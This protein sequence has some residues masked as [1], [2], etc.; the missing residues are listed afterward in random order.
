MPQFPLDFDTDLSCPL[1]GKR[2]VCP[3]VLW[4]LIVPPLSRSPKKSG[5]PLF[6]EIPIVKPKAPPSRLLST[7]SLTFFVPPLASPPLHPDFLLLHTF[8]TPRGLNPAWFFKQPE[9]RSICLR[10]ST[11]GATRRSLLVWDQNF[12][13]CGVLGV[14]VVVVWGL[15]LLRC[16]G[17]FGGLEC[18][19]VFFFFLRGRVVGVFCWVLVLQPD[20][21]LYPTFS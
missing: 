10:P 2:F 5:S 1:T 15:V 16:F 21:R 7:I 6:F 9:Y 12:G 4:N 11:N 14:C 17:F 20:S 13:G 18:F 8:W 3:S 19:F